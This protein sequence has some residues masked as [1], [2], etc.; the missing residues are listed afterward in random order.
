MSLG[1]DGSHRRYDPLHDEWVLVVPGRAAL[2]AKVAGGDE[3]PPEYDAGCHLCPGNVRGGGMANPPYRTTFVFADEEAVLDEAARSSTPG[4]GLLRSATVP[5]ACRVICYAPRHDLSLA[6]MGPDGI[7]TVIDVWAEQTAELAATY[8]WVQVFEGGGAGDGPYPLHPHGR[9]WAMDAVP[10]LAE[11]E[12]RAQAEYAAR[13]TAPLLEA[14]GAVEVE[15]EERVVEVNDEWLAVVPYWAR[16]PFETLLLPRRPAARLS[17]LDGDARSGLAALLDVL[18]VKY[19][20]LFGR[21]LPHTLGWHGAPG[22]G[23]AA[24]WTLHAHVY[25][26]DPG[27]PGPDAGYEALAEPL[28]TSTPE[29]AAERLRSQRELHHRYF[30]GR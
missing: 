5:G 29:A 6:L 14:Y 9:V 25:P 21:S 1:E 8:R 10:A 27:R 30:G 4:G 2:E 12:H 20:N 28:R 11:T 26:H 18:L 3:R 13:A 17:E 22:R 7:R 24:H 15:R 16:R 19:D 23:P